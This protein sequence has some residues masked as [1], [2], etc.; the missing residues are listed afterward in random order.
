MSDLRGV[1]IMVAPNGARRGKGDHPNI[2]LST[3][4]LAV[5]ATR[6]LEAGA[7]AIHVH[8]R[9]GEGRHVLDGPLYAEAI[10]KIRDA[11]GDKLVVQ[12]TTEAVGRYEP[13]AQIAV[14]QD[15]RPEAVSIALS[16]IIRSPED[17]PRAA[18]FFAWL[19]TERIWPQ[20]ILYRPFEIERLMDFQRRG[21]IP[22]AKPCV[23]F[24]L[25]RY[26][27]S[28]GTPA[29]LPPFLEAFGDLDTDWAVCAFGGAEAQC[30]HDAMS[31]GGHVRVGFENNLLLPSGKT[32]DTNADLVGV[33]A[34]A[35]RDQ[36][37]PVL[38]ANEIRAT[39]MAHS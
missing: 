14:V 29:D 13:P 6:C 1:M 26:G 38:T 7:G 16:E 9:D 24:V 3:D 25:G 30:A 28:E 8:V 37:R 35:A 17:E 18:R 12:I 5:E 27:Q 4:E 36:G 11:V 39:M 19:Q 15:V 23:L 2:P 33:V 32:A 34:N 10:G 20:I 31:S 21:I 22:F